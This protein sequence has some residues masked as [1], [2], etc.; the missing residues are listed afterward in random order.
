MIGSPEEIALRK[1]WVDP[2]QI[3]A[4]FS[5]KEAKSDY[6]SKV[7]QIVNELA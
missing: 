7:L 5:K 6:G 3:A 2:D 1:G 4:S